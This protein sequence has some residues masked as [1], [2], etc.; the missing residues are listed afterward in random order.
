[1]IFICR[2]FPPELTAILSKNLSDTLKLQTI[3]RH[4]MVDDKWQVIAERSYVA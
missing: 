2:Y 4:A 3:L 1:M